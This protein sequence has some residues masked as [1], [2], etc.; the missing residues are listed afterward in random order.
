MGGPAAVHDHVRWLS[1]R[2]HVVA[3]VDPPHSCSP[4]AD[5]SFADWTSFLPGT[6]AGAVGR[7]AACIHSFIAAGRD[8]IC[9]V[10]GSLN[11]R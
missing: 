2:R 1:I 7:H 6:G 4:T 11:R 8:I 9:N 10:M 5:S 3:V